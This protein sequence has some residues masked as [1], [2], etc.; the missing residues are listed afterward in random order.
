MKPANTEKL[1]TLVNRFN[2]IIIPIIE[3]GLRIQE[4]IKIL[5]IKVR[6][7]G[8]ILKIINS[9]LIKHASKF[10]IYASYPS[11]KLTKSELRF[12]KCLEKRG[13]QIIIVTNKAFNENIHN[14]YFKEDWVF[15]FRR[16]FGR[17]FGCYKDAVNIIYEN[18]KTEA[19]LER[20]IFLND[21]VHIFSNFENKLI[22]QLDD[23]SYDWSGITENYDSNHHVSS[24]MFSLS[25][26]ALFHKK[27]RKFWDKYRSFSTRKYSIYRG[28]VGLSKALKKA[29]FNPNVMYTVDKMKN[30]L[31]KIS[32]LELE[33]IY[34]LMPPSYLK[35]NS[36]YLNKL[37][38]NLSDFIHDNKEIG[39]VPEKNNNINSTWTRFKK[40]I[41]LNELK[42]S[43]LNLNHPITYMNSQSSSDFDDR[44][45]Y[46]VRFRKRFYSIDEDDQKSLLIKSA[47]T[48][49]INE[50]VTFTFK[51]SQ[52]HHAYPIL[53]HMEIGLIKKDSVYRE[54]IEPFNLRYVFDQLFPSCDQDEIEEMAFELFAKGHPYSF[55]TNFKKTALYRWGFI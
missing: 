35:N 53:L 23:K 32:L 40:K 39:Y 17:D 50:L 52:V 47:R 41:E 2:S 9:N 18:F 38:G 45:T 28:E 44:K 3:Y 11:K 48:S 31:S 15:I 1:F 37:D 27:I 42:S 8:F 12:L 22:D 6:G 51:G 7:E 24:Y 20:V 19:D 29:G 26:S 36:G 21:S 5:I 25:A 14:M 16:P 34:N 54:I 49:A 4:L 13:Y 43:D 10:A 30:Y 55:L 46:I 33:K